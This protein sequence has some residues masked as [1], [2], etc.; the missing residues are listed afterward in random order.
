MKSQALLS[1]AFVLAFCANFLHS[2]AFFGYLHLPGFLADTGATEL[3]IGVVIGAMAASA[4]V[5]RP[6]IGEL[7]DRRGRRIIARLGSVVHLLATLAY[8]TIGDVGPWLFVVRVVHGAAEAML[9]SVL[10]TIAADVAPP[11][12]R[13][14]AIALFGV[15]GLLPMSLSGLMGDLILA[16][17]GYAELFIATAVVAGLGGLCAW[18]LPD[19]RPAVESDAPARR[20]FL[21]AVMQRPLRPIWWLG[22]T[23]A[24]AISSY[25]TFLK[26][27]IEHTGT[28]SMGL[29]YTVYSVVAIILRLGLGWLPDRFGPR[30]TLYPAIL[31]TTGGLLLLPVASNNLEMGVSGMLCGMGHAF[32]FPILLAMVVER[33]AASERGVALS[34]FT[35]LFDLGLLLGSPL[36]GALLERTD[37]AVMFTSA[38]LVTVV[39]GIVYALWDRRATGG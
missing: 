25:F 6:F 36:L 30:R 8:L 15:S 2:L 22:L 21:A 32:V 5:L 33:A 11:S 14:E 28:G 23:F 12:R 20:S 27:F 34:M 7:L 26:T 10:F 18:P 1:R 35:A 31:A 4:I 38:A 17:A 39:G 3:T 13:T 37:Y 16:Q 24:T 19:S 9:F 29:F